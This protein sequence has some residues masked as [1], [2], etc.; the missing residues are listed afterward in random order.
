MAQ[1]YKLLITMRSL[2]NIVRTVQHMR[3][4]TGDAINTQLSMNERLI[5]GDLYKMGVLGGLR[6]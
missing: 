6:G 4:L 3:S 2:D 1:D 5:L